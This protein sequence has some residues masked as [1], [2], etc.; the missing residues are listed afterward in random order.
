MLDGFF[1]GNPRHSLP[2][3]MD[4]DF[5]GGNHCFEPKPLLKDPL[6]ARAIAA[7]FQV[8]A[9]KGVVRRVDGCGRNGVFFAVLGMFCGFVA[10]GSAHV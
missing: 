6:Q 5:L 8:S 7:C 9:P 2:E 1:R 3:F 4:C 10:L